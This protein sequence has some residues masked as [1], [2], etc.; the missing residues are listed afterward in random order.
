[1]D[2]QIYTNKMNVWYKAIYIYDEDCEG[3]EKEKCTR[4]R[5]WK[6]LIQTTIHRFIHMCINVEKIAQDRD[7]L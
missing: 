5:R 4:Q 7:C 1:M 6:M 3:R 2:F